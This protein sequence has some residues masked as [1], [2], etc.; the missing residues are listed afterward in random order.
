M[1]TS[2]VKNAEPRAME[3]VPFGAADKIKLTVQIVK[4]LC[5]T[6]TAQGKLC[7]D[8]Q[9]IKFMMMCSA[10]HLNPFAGDAYLIGYDGRN[11]PEYSMIT[12]HQALL[13]RAEASKEFDGM[14][15]GTILRDRE[16]GELTQPEGDF[17]DEAI[18]ELVG[19]WARVHHKGHKIPTTRRAALKTFVKTYGL[20]KDPK[21][22][23]MMIVKCVEADA[24]RST[25]PTLMGGLYTQ[26]E[27]IDLEPETPAKRGARLVSTITTDFATDNSA[28]TEE[29]APAKDPVAANVSSRPTKSDVP[30]LQE[31]LAEIL[32]TTGYTFDQF[33]KWADQ[34][35]PAVQAGS[36]GA[37]T[38]LSNTHAKLFIRGRTGMLQGLAEMFKPE[39]ALP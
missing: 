32:T 3:Y 25:F 2:L 15:S 20:W 5:C 33:Q 9:A 16:S 38:D 1:N 17:Y 12:A 7:D 37:F 27:V 13:K 23:A 26:A 39:P 8:K 6:P 10:Q 14:E 21:N 36:I 34:E 24:L 22:H 19:G 29:P 18:H 30:T 35:F 4:D 31:E 28:H 11:G